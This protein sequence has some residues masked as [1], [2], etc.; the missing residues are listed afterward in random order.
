MLMEHRPHA[1]AMLLA[2]GSRFCFKALLNP[3]I[4]S[5]YLDVAFKAKL[6]KKGKRGLVIITRCLCQHFFYQ[7]ITHVLLYP[8]QW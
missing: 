2:K 1:K 8:H 4:D 5:L 6:S 3:L 7:Q